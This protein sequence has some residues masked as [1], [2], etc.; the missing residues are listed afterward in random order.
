M[1]MALK[2][3]RWTRGDLDR[4]PDDG[5]RYEV[6]NG[7]L[8]VTP[9]P[10]PAHEEL[11]HVFARHL[12]PFL[13]A[14]RLGSVFNGR[15]AVILG[16]NH[17]EPDL[18]VRKRLVPPPPTWDQVP[19]P[20]LVVEVLSPTTIRRDEI[21]KRELYQREGIPEYWIVNGRARTVRVI[22]PAG[23]R[24][25]ALAL[26]WQPPNTGATLDLDLRA[27]FEEALGAG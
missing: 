27:L 7:E 14:H 19:R 9:P 21:A 2:T 12:Q 10:S 17:V 8:F 1:H 26:R 15:S 16:E 24:V 11:H 13:D 22:T 3:R 5:N 25:E 20:I 23:E 6:V 4:L 18:V